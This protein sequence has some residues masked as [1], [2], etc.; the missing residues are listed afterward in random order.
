MLIL[1]IGYLS[2]FHTVVGNRQ[3]GRIVEFDVVF[4]RE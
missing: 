3:I 1:L 2:G 4:T